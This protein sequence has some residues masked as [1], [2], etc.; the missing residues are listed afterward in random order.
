M[1]ESNSLSEENEVRSETPETPQ[2]GEPSAVDSEDA[3]DLFKHSASDDGLE[4]S[5]DLLS[6]PDKPRGAWLLQIPRTI[7]R[8]T[9]LSKNGFGGLVKA[10]RKAGTTTGREASM[11][12]K[13]RLEKRRMQRAAERGKNRSAE[14]EELERQVEVSLQKLEGFINE[15]TCDFVSLRYSKKFWESLY[16]L[17]TLRK[18]IGK[19][20]PVWEQI[21]RDIPEEESQA[22]CAEAPQGEDVEAVCATSPDDLRE[23]PDPTTQDERE[24]TSEDSIRASQPK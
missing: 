3:Y 18:K 15:R 4:E 17:D 16:R 13:N 21:V 24:F 9:R 23:S 8:A 6:E 19:A 11:R 10:A 7:G 1:S 2:G 20:Q 22:H 5:S 14:R 12:I